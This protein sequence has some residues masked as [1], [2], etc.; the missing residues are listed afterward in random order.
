VLKD[1][2]KTL[3]VGGFDKTRG[4]PYLSWSKD[5]GSS[6]TDISA[7]VPGYA[8]VADDEYSAGSVSAIMQDPQGR[9]IVV[10]NERADGQG[11]LMQLTLGDK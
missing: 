5:G 11:R 8:S 4:R 9:I 3:V 2:P 10:V 1:Q 7:M 6:W